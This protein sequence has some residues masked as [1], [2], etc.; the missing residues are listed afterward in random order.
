MM[1]NGLIT[2]VR[3]PSIGHS[4]KVPQTPVMELMQLKPKKAGLKINPSKC[5]KRDDRYPTT[6]LRQFYIILLRSFLILWRDRSLTAMRVCIH[7]FVAPIIGLLY[8]GIGNDGYHTYNNYKYAFF[9]IMFLMYTAFSS[10]ILVCKFKLNLKF[11]LNFK[12]LNFS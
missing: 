6:F 2:P 7:L 12:G 5:C 3:A 10:I 9:S 8:F 11:A 4:S 1:S